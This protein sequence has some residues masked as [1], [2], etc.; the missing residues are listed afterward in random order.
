LQRGTKT[1]PGANYIIRPD[2]RRKKITD[3]TKEALLEE[4]QPGFIVERHLMDGDISI[5]NR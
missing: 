5:F 1:Y 2:G 3:E 4:L